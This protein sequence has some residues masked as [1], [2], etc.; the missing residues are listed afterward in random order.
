M[1]TLV[2]QIQQRFAGGSG[3]EALGDVAPRLEQRV[4]DQGVANDPPTERIVVDTQ[5]PF[6]PQPVHER[7]V[8]VLVVV[9]HHVRGNIGHGAAHGRYAVAE[10]RDRIGFLVPGFWRH[11]RQ[12]R[13]ASGRIARTPQHRRPGEQVF[14]AK[15]S[16]EHRVVLADHAFGLAQVA[17]DGDGGDAFAFGRISGQTGAQ[18]G[19]AREPTVGNT[20]PFQGCPATP[21][22]Q[23]CSSGQAGPA[24]LPPSRK[25]HGRP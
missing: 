13:R 20:P 11:R 19:S 14:R 1:L 5:D 21:N 18:R 22:G 3:S 8:G 17:L 2:E 6:A 15:F 12:D 10:P 16:E 24:S 4:G 9:A 7:V 25:D 23:V